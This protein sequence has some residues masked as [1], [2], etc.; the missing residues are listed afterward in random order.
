MDPTAFGLGRD[1]RRV[2]RINEQVPDLN[3]VVCTGVYAFAELPGFLKD[4]ST[5]AL[6][7][8]FVRELR[9]G[10]DTPASRPAS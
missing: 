9:E 10:I 3:I 6:T 4:R 5:D 1:V 8:L 2:A 7:Q